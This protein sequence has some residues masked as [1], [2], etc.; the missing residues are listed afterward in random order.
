M[1]TLASL[2]MPIIAAAVIV[3]TATVAKLVDVR[4]SARGLEP[5]AATRYRVLRRSVVTAIVFV[6]ITSALLV[7]PQVR[8]VA[9]GILASSAVVAVVLGFAAQP[10]DA[11]LRLGG[12]RLGPHQGG[13]VFDK[14]TCFECPLHGWQFDRATGRCLNAPSRALAAI[15]VVEEDGV[16]YADIPEPARTDRVGHGGRSGKA[17]LSIHLHSHACLELSYEGFTLLT[18]PWLD[19]PAFLGAWALSPPTR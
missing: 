11:R 9:G 3:G 16:L 13:A 5:A 7:I 18:D 15:P 12:G 10:D 1:T 6:G 17:G 2:W 8:T 4:I 14:G 19:G